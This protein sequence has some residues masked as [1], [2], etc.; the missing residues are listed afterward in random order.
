MLGPFYEP[1]APE[2]TSVG[3]GYVLSGTVL[4]AGSCEPIRDA[5]I[6]FWLTD[7]GAC[8]MTRTGSPS[9]SGSGEST[10]SR[11]TCPWRAKTGRPTSTS[12]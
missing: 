12:G 3:S 7:P 2:R 5:R 9:R 10:G 1:D 8:T 6:E 4:A 11:A